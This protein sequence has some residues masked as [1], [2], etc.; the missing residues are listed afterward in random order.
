MTAAARPRAAASLPDLADGLCPTERALVGALQ[1]ARWHKAS[2]VLER[3]LGRPRGARL[4][5]LDP[6]LGTSGRRWR[7]LAD[8]VVR[9]YA[10]LVDLAAPHRIRQPLA[11]ARGNFGSPAGDP[12]ADPVYCQARLTAWGAAVR[13]GAA[14]GLLVNGARDDRGTLCFAPHNLGE[15]VPILC[16]CV[17]GHP[18]ED[19]LAE[20]PLVPDFPTGGV[21]VA[22]AREVAA[23]GRGRLRLRARL[24]ELRHSDVTAIVATE[25]PFG[26]DHDDVILAAV[27][28]ARAGALGGVRD[29]RDE[30][31]A[32]GTRLVFLGA[33]GASPRAMT[34]ALLAHTQLEVE[35]EVVARAWDGA[36]IAR[37]ALPA[38]VAG[39][40]ARLV[41]RARAA[42]PNA[43]VRALRRAVVAELHALGAAHADARRTELRP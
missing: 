5:P 19:A 18:A 7:A 27:A 24:A 15:L 6:A 33:R 26:V 40:A 4:P 34:A 11:Q 20:R 32:A 36:R 29:V 9:A 30:S 25:I 31:T 43:Y 16:A 8:P 38:L 13:A 3:A 28:L 14:P 17:E 42:R 10:R 39:E 21:L 1:L 35:L 12:P 41:E 22:G 37:P 23:T 2:L